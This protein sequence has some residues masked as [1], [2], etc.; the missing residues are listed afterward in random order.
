MRFLVVFLLFSISVF[1]QSVSPKDVVGLCSGKRVIA[2]NPTGTLY[3]DLKTSCFEI[4][5]TNTLVLYYVEIESGTTFTFEVTPLEDIDYDFASWLNPNF[6]NL[7]ESDRGSQNDPIPVGLYTTGLSMLEFTQTCEVG[8][9]FE[10]EE[11]G[12]IPGMVRY[13]DVKPGDGILIALNR[14][15]DKDGGFEISFGGDAILDCDLEP[16]IYEKCDLDND[17][18]GEF[19]L[20]EISADFK[21]V[22]N[23]FIIDF[24]ENQEDAMSIHATNVLQS[25]YVVEV[26]DSPKTIYARFL[27]ANGVY[28]KTIEIELVVL[29]TP[30]IPSRP[31]RYEQCNYGEDEEMIF[32]L[33]KFEDSLTVLNNVF[34]TFTYYEN[35]EDALTE[36]NRDSMGDKTVNQIDSP[37]NYKSGSRTIYIVSDIDGRCRVIVPLELKVNSIPVLPINIVLSDLCGNGNSEESFN[38]YN[39]IDI[40]SEIVS[41]ALSTVLYEVTFYRSQ[42]DVDNNN[43]LN[44]PAR[45]NVPFGVN[46]NIIVRFENKNGCYAFTTINLSSVAP[47]QFE[48][49]M[50][51]NCGVYELEGLPEGYRYYLEPGGQG[52]EIIVGSEDSIIRKATE[53]YVYG[54]KSNL[55]DGKEEPSIC[56]YETKFK[57][58]IVGCKVPRGV[59]PNG[60]GFNDFW[61]LSVFEI[62]N[63]K[64]YN[65][66][67][68]EV[69]SYGVGYTTEWWGQSADGSP[70]PDG[71]YWYVIDSFEGKKEGW[72]FINK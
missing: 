59:S 24:F 71:T 1:G 47:K 42:I 60:D 11:T 35:E 41:P 7:G 5:L 39:L 40:L 12:V 65:R 19:D 66:Y 32:D 63:L 6:E 26:A 55:V 52:K 64:I 18:K 4:P 29:K 70:L 13:Y 72:V 2:S 10:P 53:I 67:G 15:S 62:Y 34:T 31:L 17:D 20:L 57:V 37:G 58:Q 25:P 69:F 9:A 30:K 56:V 61:D 23:V 16:K 38:E 44:D 51:N 27:R 3:D 50:I 28:A 33:T 48:D 68:K 49:Q 36:V 22:N 46:E 54:N 45:F 21:N 43:P 14:W 8:G